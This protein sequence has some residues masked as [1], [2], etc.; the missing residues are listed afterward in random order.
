MHGMQRK[1]LAKQD[2]G[3]ARTG[4]ACPKFFNTRRQQ[5]PRQLGAEPFDF[6]ARCRSWRLW[7]VAGDTGD[8]A[9]WRRACWGGAE[10]HPLRGLAGLAANTG[11]LARSNETAGPSVH[12]KLLRIPLQS[13]A[14][15]PLLPPILTPPL[16]PLFFSASSASSTS[17]PSRL[18]PV[19]AASGFGPQTPILRAVPSAVPPP[20]CLAQFS[21]RACT[22]L[23]LEPVVPLSKPQ[24]EPLLDARRSTL[25]AVDTLTSSLHC[26]T[27]GR[28]SIDRR[29]LYSPHDNRSR[30][31]PPSLLR[32]TA[33]S[34][35]SSRSESS[36]T[37]S[38]PGT[39]QRAFSITQTRGRHPSSVTRSRG[40]PKP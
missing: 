27:A 13:A 18:P 22:R 1:H 25:C 34:P 36:A 30:G 37:C 17:L 28:A 10:Q 11:T 21:A 2:D 3:G 39:K 4:D 15:I 29:Y 32:Q 6:S 38:V 12:V 33:I 31:P 35:P 8:A 26:R 20:C 19:C 14:Y 24:P 9:S 16:L 23:N 7:R 5:V 40:W